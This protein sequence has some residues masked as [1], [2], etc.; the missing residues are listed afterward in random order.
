MSDVFKKQLKEKIQNA[1]KQVEPMV[2]KSTSSQSI[3][4]NGNTQV[5]NHQRINQD[6][7]GNDNLQVAGDVGDE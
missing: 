1:L 2:G 5:G 4:G 6:I 3:K 7:E